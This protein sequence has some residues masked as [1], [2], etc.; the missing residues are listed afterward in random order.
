M[1]AIPDIYD[2]DA[3]HLIAATKNTMTNSLT[4]VKQRLVEGQQIRNNTNKYL[5]TLSGEQRTKHIKLRNKL[6]RTKK[7]NI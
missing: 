2:D 7:C 5:A 1:N 4:D 3:F 6:N